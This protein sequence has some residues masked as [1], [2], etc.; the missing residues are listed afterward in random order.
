MKKKIK[1]LETSLELFKQ[2]Q[3][4]LSDLRPELHAET[5]RIINAV[6][7]SERRTIRNLYKAMWAAHAARDKYREKIGERAIKLNFRRFYPASLSSALEAIENGWV[8]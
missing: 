5:K 3:G 8:K 4:V 2:H 7:P 6:T 1:P